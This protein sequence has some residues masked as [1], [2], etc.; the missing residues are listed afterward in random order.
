MIPNPSL[1]MLGGDGTPVLL[2]HGYGSDQ[3]SW[4]ATA[5]ALFACA[6]VWVLDLPAHG[7]SATQ[8]GD[9]SPH[10][11]ANS[12]LAAL[13]RANI[14]KLHLIGHSLGGRI[15]MEMAT[16]RPYQILSLGL[17]SP[18]GVNESINLDFLTRFYQ[19]NSEDTVSKLLSMLVHDPR[20]IAPKLA[21]AVLHYLQKPGVRSSL[22]TICAALNEASTSRTKTLSS[23]NSMNI[24]TIS[25]WGLQDKINAPE[26]LAIKELEGIAK[27]LDNCG[28]LP[29]IEKRTKVNELLCAFIS[30]HQAL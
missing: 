25:I 4:V 9:G 17:L 24:P 18:A 22:A 29:H 21:S 6:Q 20:L 10:T 19:A 1:S 13:D 23:L 8:C 7:T 30:K 15:A 12:I 11:L 2:I 5:P 28:H 3:H 14:K 16:L 27:M 26:E